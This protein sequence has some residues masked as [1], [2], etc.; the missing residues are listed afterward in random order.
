MSARSIMAVIKSNMNSPIMKNEAIVEHE[1]VL[2][3]YV[4]E[5]TYEALETLEA[6]NQMGSVYSNCG[7]YKKA[8]GILSEALP[9][10]EKAYGV[11]GKLTRNIARGV[12]AMLREGIN[13]GQIV[14]TPFLKGQE[15]RI[16]RKYGV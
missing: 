16:R 6:M 1:A 3:E 7:E 13:A 12:I 5:Y 4:E 8:Y 9:K 2:A 11:K 10:Y 15:A 14:P